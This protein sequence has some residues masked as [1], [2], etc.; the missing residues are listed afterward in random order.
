MPRPLCSPLVAPAG[1]TCS[2]PPT[3]W[4]QQEAEGEK[5]QPVL[6][7]EASGKVAEKDAAGTACW[8]ETAAQA[9]CPSHLLEAQ[10]TSSS[11]SQGVR[12]E[13]PG[14]RRASW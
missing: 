2:C 11:K 10:G 9:W 5:V 14:N 8:E 13:R 7:A 6:S 4:T 12:A 1:A 3:G